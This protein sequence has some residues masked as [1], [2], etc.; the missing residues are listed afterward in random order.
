MKRI[1]LFCLILTSFTSIAQVRKLSY[2]PDYSPVFLDMIGD[3]FKKALIGGLNHPQFQAL[4]INNDGKKDLVLHDRTGGM[5]LPYINTGKGGIAN[6]QY[7][8][9]FVQ[10]F[11]EMDQNTWMMLVDYDN[12]GREDLWTKLNFKTV[13]YRNVTKSGDKM[14]RFEKISDY[15]KAYNFNPPPFPDSSSI[16]ADNFN[17]P[18]IGDVD[19]DGDIDFFSYQANEG[20]LLLYR[21]MTKDFNL[22]LHPPVFDIADFCWGDFRDTTYDGIRLRGCAF[23]YYRKHSGGSTLLW[24]DND[25]DGDMDLIMGNA[26]G[27]NL[28]FLKN[29][30]SDLKLKFD[31]MISYDGHWPA[32]STPLNLG[33]FPGAFLLD[34]DEDGVKDILVAPNQVE[35]VYRIEETKQVWWYKNYGTNALPV[36]KLEQKNYFTDEIVDHGAYTAPNLVDID[37]DKDLDLII[38]TNGDYF[39]TGDA[40]YRLVLYRNIGTTKKAVFKLENEDLW[41]LS[42]DSLVLLNVTF[43]DLNGDNKIDM[44]AGNYYGNLHFYKNIGTSTSWAFTKPVRDYLGLNVGES[45]SPQLIDLDKNGLLDLVIGEKDGNFNYYKNTG[46]TSSPNFVLVDDTLGDFFV[47]EFSYKQ[48]PPGYWYIG[49]AAGQIA[50]LDMD[51]KPDMVFGGDEGRVRVMKFDNYLQKK[52]IEDTLVLFDSARM[53]YNTFDV[54]NRSR[55]AVGDLDGDGVNDILVGNDRGGLNYFKGTVEISKVEKRQVVQPSIYPN[56]VNGRYLNILNKNAEA[57]TYS[58]FD[59][60]GKLVLQNEA[61][62]GT[63]IY[64]LDMSSLSQGIYILKCESSLGDYFYFRVL[65]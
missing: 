31:S 45:S 33:S 44:L 17:I 42:A 51:G 39:K 6:Y 64:Q 56:P 53:R 52:Y 21:N 19:N 43:G 16:S 48:N 47:N 28:I 36:F 41:N 55:P 46:N 5:L 11:P 62:A 30:K 12:D 57:Y 38:A 14:V 18:A 32:N 13:L 3:T 37:G 50:D 24:L 54:G 1:L 61:S 26:G 29:G 2:K 25:N 60:S 23:K 40:N 27:N 34:V 58:L 4:D 63:K 15:L 8:P 9:Y 35:K 10:A 22:P 7:R 49:N 65:K 59:L 20:N